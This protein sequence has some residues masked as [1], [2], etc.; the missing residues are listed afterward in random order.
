MIVPSVFGVRGTDING[1]DF[2]ILYL[3]IAAISDGSS[4]CKIELESGETIKLRESRDELQ[5]RIAPYL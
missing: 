5:A 1:D 2:G 3:Q 4:G